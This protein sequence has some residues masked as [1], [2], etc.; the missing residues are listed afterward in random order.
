MVLQA[1]RFQIPAGTDRQVEISLPIRQDDRAEEAPEKTAYFELS[2]DPADRGTAPPFVST[3]ATVAI[4]DDDIGLGILRT[5]PAGDAVEE[6][7]AVTFAVTRRGDPRPAVTVPYRIGGAGIGADDYTDRTISPQPGRVTVAAGATRAE[8]ALVIRPDGQREDPET[9]TVTI[10]GAG[11][12][13][14]TVAGAHRGTLSILAAAGTA[15]TA[16]GAT[17]RARVTIRDA[18]AVRPTVTATVRRVGAEFVRDDAAATEAQRTATFEFALS[19]PPV[20]PVRVQT[21]VTGV[22]SGNIVT[23]PIAI[24]GETFGRLGGEI[25]FPTGQTTRTARAVARPDA[26]IE[27]D[28]TFTVTLTA[29]NAGP[30]A[31]NFAIGT[32]S[33]ATATIVDGPFLVT[34]RSKVASIREPVFGRTDPVPVGFIFRARNKPPDAVLAFKTRVNPPGA[35]GPAT[36]GFDYNLRSMSGTL[37]QEITIPARQTEVTVVANVVP[38][39][40]LEG[41]ETLTVAIESITR[42]TSGQG[43]IIGSPSSATVTVV[44][45]TSPARL[46]VAGS[47]SQTIRENEVGSTVRHAEFSLRLRRVSRPDDPPIGGFGSELRSTIR[48]AAGAITV[49]FTVTGPGDSRISSLSAG[50]VDP[51][52]RGSIVIPRSVQRGT[53]AAARAGHGITLRPHFSRNRLNEKQRKV[54]ISFGKPTTARGT[55]ELPEVLRADGTRG[56]PQIELVVL[57]R[58]GD[59]IS[60]SLVPPARLRV[61]EGETLP[62]QLR[63]GGPCRTSS[64]GDI[65]GICNSEPVVVRYAISGEGITDGITAG[66]F[67]ALPGQTGSPT[68]LSGSVSIT[69][70]TPAA[71][72]ALVD[73]PIGIA[74]DGAGEGEERFTLT[75][76]AVTTAGA[77]RAEGTTSSTATVLAD[78]DVLVVS[79]A[80]PAPDDVFREGGVGPDERAPFTL[81][82]ANGPPTAAVSVPYTLSGAG[83]EAGDVSA[84]GL[85]ENSLRGVATIPSGAAEATLTLTAVDDNRFEDHETVTVT[86]E[87]PTTTG[88]DTVQLSADPDRQSAAATLVDDEVLTVSIAGPAA[89]APFREDGS[90]PTA[91]ARFTLRVTGGT[92]TA[93]LRI[94]YRVTGVTEGDVRAPGLRRVDRVLRGTLGF[95]PGVTEATLVFTAQD[96]RVFEG[97]ERMTV[98]LELPEQAERIRFNPDR[99]AVQL[100]DNDAPRVSW[101]EPKVRV[102]EG[103]THRLGLRVSYS[104]PSTAA[105]PIFVTYRV[106][107]A[108]VQLADFGELPGR[109]TCP[110]GDIRRACPLRRTL[111]LDTHTGS[112]PVWSKDFSIDLPLRDDGPNEGSEVATFELVRVVGGYAVDSARS[113]LELTIVDFAPE[114]SIEGPAADDVFREGGVGADA[115]APFRIFLNETLTADVSVPFTVTGAGLSAADLRAS[116]GAGGAAVELTAVTAGAGAET[117]LRGT[118]TIPSGSDAVAL[119]LSAENDELAE[120]DETVTVTLGTPTRAG[121]AIA[122]GSPASAAATLVD[123]DVGVSIERFEEDREFREGGAGVRER[124]G[125]DDADQASFTIRITRG[126]PTADLVV[127]YTLSGV[128][129][130]DLDAGPAGRMGLGGTVTLALGT[131]STRLVLTAF[132]DTEVEGL[133]ILTVTLVARTATTGAMGT[134]APAPGASRATAP[135]VDDDATARIGVRKLDKDDSTVA[136]G[137]SISFPLTV[138]GTLPAAGFSLTYTITGDRITPGDFQDAAGS[139]L[140]SLRQ[141]QRFSATGTA[142]KL[143]LHVRDDPDYEGDDENFTVTLV[144]TTA[145]T[146]D[147]AN[148]T[149]SGIIQDTDMVTVAFTHSTSTASP[150]R[151]VEGEAFGFPLTFTPPAGGAI[152]GAVKLQFGINGQVSRRDF[153]SGQVTDSG[154]MFSLRNGYLP[155]F[156]PGTIRSGASLALNTE[157]DTQREGPENFILTLVETASNVSVGSRAVQHAR[158]ADN[159][160]EVSIAGPPPNDVFREGATGPDRQ[161]PFVVRIKAGTPAA[162]LGIPFTVTGEGLS[163]GDLSASLGA[164]GA[165]VELT[166]VTAGAGAVTELRGTVTISAGESST[167]L[168]LIAENDSEVENRETLTVTLVPQTATTGATATLVPVSGAAS[169]TAALDDDDVLAVSIERTTGDDQFREGGAGAADSGGVGHADE[170]SFTIS[171]TGGTPTAAVTVPYTLSGTIEAAKDLEEG[172]A[173]RNGLV[174]TV[175]IGAGETSTTLI[176]T[177]KDDMEDENDET[178]TVTLADEQMRRPTTPRGTVMVAAAPANAATATLVDNDGVPTVSIAGPAPDDVFREGGA[179]AAARA[180]FTITARG[181]IPSGRLSI[182]YA[183][184]GPGVKV[185]DFRR[186]R[187]DGKRVDLRSLT[188]NMLTLTSNQLVPGPVTA[189]LVLVAY[190]DPL[191]EDPETVKVTLGVTAGTAVLTAG[192]ESAEATLVDNDA[193]SVSIART[194]GDDEFREGGAGD[195]EE[196]SFTITL[197]GGTSTAKVRV[198]FT[199]TGVSAEDLEAT[200]VSTGS[201][202]SQSSISL[203]ARD[204]PARLVGEAVVPAGGTSATLIFTAKDDDLVE[205]AETLRVELGTPTTTGVARLAP[206]QA[207][208]QATLADNDALTVGIGAASPATREE[209]GSAFAFP[210]TFAGGVPTG[211]VT[212]TY[213]LSD[214][215]P[216][217]GIIAGDLATAG[218]G[219]TRT[220]LSGLT[221]Q[222]VTFTV[223]QIRGARAPG[224]SALT[225]ELFAVDDDA[226]EDPETFRV[227]LTGV[228]VGS[229]AAGQKTATG[230]IQ[231]NDALTL[232]IA[233]TGG[234]DEFREGGAGEAG[235]ASFTITVTGGTPPA[236]VV[237]PFTVTGVSV[238]DL[239]ETR[240]STGSGRGS[241]ITLTAR[242]APARLEGEVSVPA[243]TES[244][245]PS[246]RLS[247]RLIFTAVEDALAEGDETLTVTLVDEPMRRPTTTQGEVMLSRAAGATRAEATL[248]DDGTLSVSITR[249][250]GDLDFREGGADIRDRGGEGDADEASFTITLT[251]GT[252]TAEVV[253]PFTVTGV[254]Q[255]DITASSGELTAATRR[256]REFLDGSVTI[257]AGAPSA[258]LVLTAKKDGE[259]EGDE[260]LAVT[261]V[262]TPTTARGA[263]RRASRR[264]GEPNPMEATATLVDDN[265]LSVSIVRTSMDDEFREGGAGAA[266]SGGVGAADEVSFT[267][268]LAGG[269]PTAPVTIPYTLGGTIEAADLVDGPAGR[270][271]LTGTVTIGAGETEAMLVFTAQQDTAPEGDETLTV[272]L[273]DEPMRRPTTPRGTVMLSGVAG[274]TRAEATLE[275][276]DALTLR[277]VPDPERA[278]F[279]VEEGAAFQFQIEIEG[280]TPAPV[281]IRGRYRVVFPTASAAAQAAPASTADLD[282]AT[283]GAFTIAAGEI[284]AGERGTAKTFSIATRENEEIKADRKRF[285]IELEG[286]T[287]AGVSGR[288]AA[289][290][291]QED[292]LRLVMTAPAR[293]AE[294]APVTFTIQREGA[295]TPPVTVEYVVSGVQ[296]GDFLHPPGGVDLDNPLRGRVEFAAGSDRAKLV[297]GIEDDDDTE[298]KTLAVTLLEGSVTGVTGQVELVGPRAAVL[299]SDS[300]RLELELEPEEPAGGTVAEGISETA[301]AEARYRVRLVGSRPGLSVEVS[302]GVEVSGVA[303]WAQAADFAGGTLPQSE[304]PLTLRQASGADAESFGV[305]VAQDEALEGDERFRVVVQGGSQTVAVET[306]IVDDEVGVS[307]EA[308]EGLAPEGGR[309]EFAFTRTGARDVGVTL[310][311]ELGGSAQAADYRDPAGG[312]LELA[313]GQRTATVAIEIVADGEREEDETLELRVVS[314]ATAA[315]SAGVAVIVGGGRASVTIVDDADQEARRELRTRA[316]LAAT[317]RAAA[318]LATEAISRRLGRRS[319]EA[320][321]SAR[322]DREAQDAEP[323]ARREDPEWRDGASERGG[324]PDGAPTGGNA[325]GAVQRIAAQAPAAG[326]GAQRGAAQAEPSGVI[327]LDAN[328]E[329]EAATGALPPSAGQRA[330]RGE[331]SDA[332][333]SSSSPVST[334]ERSEGLHPS[335]RAPAQPSEVIHSKPGP[336]ARARSEASEATPSGVIQP[337]VN[338]QQGLP[339]GALPPACSPASTPNAQRKAATGALPPSSGTPEGGAIGGTVVGAVQRIA[340]GGGAAAACDDAAPTPAGRHSRVRGEGSQSVAAGESAPAAG[341]APGDGTAG[342]RRG[343]EGTASPGAEALGTVLRVTGLSGVASAASRDEDAPADP[344]AEA[345]LAGIETPA[346][347]VPTG[348]RE[349]EV[350]PSAAGEPDLV[351]RL[352]SLRS[353][354][355]GVDFELRGEELGWERLGEGVSIWGSGGVTIVEGDPLLRGQRLEYEGESFGVFVGAEQRLEWGAAGAGRELV[356]GAALGWTRGDLDYTDRAAVGDFETSGRFESELMSLYPYGAVHL[357][358]RARLWVLAGYGWGEVEIEERE[359]EDGA[360]A[361]RRRVETDAWLWMVSAG[362]ESSLPLRGLGEAT[363]VVLRV[364]GTRT[365]GSLARAR[366]DDGKLLRGTR[367]R[368]WGFA[369]ELEASHRIEFGEGSHF[370]PFVTGRLRGEAGDD[371]GEDW[372]LGVDLGGGAELAWPERGLS[373]SVR[374][375]AQLNEGTGRRAHRIGADL[376]YD[377]EGDGRGLTVSVESG[378][379]GSGRFGSA[380]RERGGAATAGAGSGFGSDLPGTEELIERE[381]DGGL[382]DGSLQMRVQGEIGY[383]LL[384]RPLPWTRGLL[385]PY[386]RFEWAASRQGYAT[387]LR[388]ESAVGMKLGLEAGVDFPRG[389][390][391][392][393]AEITPDYQFLLTGELKF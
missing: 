240:V 237:V 154:G 331:R 361:R 4:R 131:R 179:G 284:A 14:P 273:V 334:T 69:T 57:D 99:A 88:G 268:E 182:S 25:V 13:R 97:D 40:V 314:A 89:S 213:E 301:G 379:D 196:A 105:G 35:A 28:E 262:G 21:A 341:A 227:T 127:P 280:N 214:E 384:A 353:L 22:Q 108:G 345:L 247:A 298:G 151:V 158:I 178:L 338:A 258:T 266:D 283:A 77:T 294:G 172:P 58:P 202:A 51:R 164:G 46:V 191:V 360:E 243:P 220:E 177:A 312:T 221:G 78:D 351:L 132:N 317:N 3:T 350:E 71:G 267:I 123:N 72:G 236:A 150:V 228:T 229:L 270:T 18:V 231:D 168:V 73:F 356:A 175:T 63:F 279:V 43:F 222:T 365:G 107:G 233:R 250:S 185:A 20:G 27:G 290:E 289:V 45:A 93:E 218:P 358:P 56:P 90:G 337:D 139:A 349:G 74:S 253:V 327:Q 121:R 197:A 7:G 176:F 281:E 8:I 373:L 122:R 275:D 19:A 80:G 389:G 264:A 148:A 364:S 60:Y 24:A 377:L 277:I 180:I 95:A 11:A 134:V 144:A 109:S 101:S 335:G 181:E 61:G 83:I 135:L 173:G 152:A 245:S 47:P 212:V 68:S 288:P 91:Q 246:S 32:P 162:D 276:D 118:V 304:V 296:E 33:S 203:T 322:R 359:G 285:A 55:V 333:R 103:S 302:W 230:T 153:A 254:S 171:V 184:R 313:P 26:R 142:R 106:S 320:R 82:V 216:G 169:A 159:D 10:G 308:A 343:A 242:D 344:Q 346:P 192:G 391:A 163:A 48:G 15:S 41:N 6:G 319:P 271:G 366:F 310:T 34:V 321:A 274:A 29:I 194:G 137:G 79:I 303:G 186:V 278:G 388:F 141:T 126:T 257:P 183:L 193:L 357:S 133:E 112:R 390:T 393:S 36:D 260:T 340:A 23:P 174:G 383:G 200:R 292:D 149:A 94:P 146:I 387:G 96:D 315:G 318:D 129:A 295:T 309:A 239:A 160:F 256:R 44:D 347:A 205:G 143:Q 198:P 62:Y 110:R 328:A 378:V 16:A 204:G 67:S 362:A 102:R 224:A 210:L 244:N 265:A 367:A 207:A 300:D 386:A 199:V 187:I 156:S 374:G 119:V 263:V 39:Q 116:L 167:S 30:A 369:G 332:E 306:V 84:P 190:D 286:L 376:S 208:A 385:T 54:T 92:R 311:Y 251:G 85:P 299:L 370:R 128:A 255:G 339:T 355:E 31:Q 272:T 100:I 215:L 232:S 329:Q 316:L 37:G 261:L 64:S 140:T 297:L 157:N 195:A 124:D 75:L 87:T 155:T 161:A 114:V 249:T 59:T 42:N 380:E 17:A 189:R 147:N 165:A 226:V 130:A 138:T 342:F 81:R 66:D 372:E 98:I 307:V 188:G 52:G 235:E 241:S 211:D 217:A 166:A 336:Q 392:S 259:V 136:E 115:E 5:A 53:E 145:G 65:R 12:Q 201:G 330:Q 225:L 282:G 293:A 2:Q 305:R 86:L 375:T 371:L 223:A 234:D 117:E 209:G 38:D 348:L 368:T 326:G 324:I 382:D 248:T 287:P 120:D 50:G 352:P 381:G 219:G 111:T 291:I 113:R 323:P 354:L 363:E 170:A 76:G 252:P 104:S 206:G 125:K 70:V 325:L 238:A 269:T 9:L 49:P 1:S